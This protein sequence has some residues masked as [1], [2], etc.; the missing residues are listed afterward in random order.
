MIHRLLMALAV[1]GGQASDGMSRG[2]AQRLAA[3]HGLTRFSSGHVRRALNL[4]GRPAFNEYR[5]PEQRSFDRAPDPSGIAW[6][7]EHRQN[8]SAAKARRRALR[9]SARA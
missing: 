6:A 7:D 4:R 1:L 3:K 2:E 8:R 5:S 9:S